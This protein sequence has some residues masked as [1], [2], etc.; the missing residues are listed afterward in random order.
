MCPSARGL[1]LWEPNHPYSN[2]LLFVTGAIRCDH[3][4]PSSLALS[5]P[6]RRARLRLRQA[7]LTGRR[8]QGFT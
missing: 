3:V 1:S 8:M 6:V 2:R 5:V 7:L 4:G